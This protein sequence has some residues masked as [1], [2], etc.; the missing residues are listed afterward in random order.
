MTRLVRVASC[1]SRREHR[2]STRRSGT[3]DVKTHRQ[4]RIE[5]KF[6]PRSEKPVSGG[7]I[8]SRIERIGRSRFADEVGDVRLDR[9]DLPCLERWRTNCA[10]RTERDAAI[11]SQT[12]STSIA[13]AVLHCSK[14]GRRA[15]NAIRKRSCS[16]E[17]KPPEARSRRFSREAVGQ[18][19]SLAL[20]MSFTACGLALPPE[21][22]IT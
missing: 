22:F 15:R 3:C 6:L 5:K 9:F 14:T 11:S 17:M 16:G 2:R 4:F 1:T 18:R 20:R 10:E 12:Y 19:P 13:R 7:G 8:R 21:D